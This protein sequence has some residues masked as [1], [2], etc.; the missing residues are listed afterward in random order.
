MDDNEIKVNADL[1]EKVK[2]LVRLYLERQGCEVMEGFEVE[3][4]K[5]DWVTKNEDGY[6]LVTMNEKPDREAFERALV[7][8]VTDHDEIDCCKLRC[9]TI[10][11][12]FVGEDRGILRWHKD[13]FG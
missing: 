8:F 9:D 2:H 5:A 10:K 3:G 1:S 4:F 11:F 6:A 12:T 13:Y 7:V